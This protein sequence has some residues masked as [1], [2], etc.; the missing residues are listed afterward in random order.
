VADVVARGLRF[1]VQRL[2]AGDRIVVF[3]HGLVM[4]NLSS[5][6]FTL[7]NAAAL[8]ARVILYDLRGHGTSERPDTG[9][10]VADMLADLDALLVALGV[11]APVQ[12][13]GNSF[14]GL[15]AL[16]FAAAFP[17]RTRS[18]A[19]VDPHLSDAEWG[20]RMMATLMLDVE[21]RDR[22]IVESFRE[23]VGRHNDRRRTRL[24]RTAEALVY[25]TSLADDLRNSRPITDDELRRVRCPVLV[26]YGEHSDVRQSGDRLAA[27]LPAC[28][29][30]VLPGCSHS[31]LWEATD[32]VRHDVLEW[33]AGEGS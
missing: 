15:L 12:L 22:R 17:E 30:R 26:F 2:G 20:E 32:L 28:E 23:W 4:D 3:L 1:N 14:G 18:L 31:V 5:W 21:E 9:Y 10:T 27:T 11:T 19:L 8:S 24:A 33:L 13:V 25:R 6:Y 7:A 29:V 16:Q